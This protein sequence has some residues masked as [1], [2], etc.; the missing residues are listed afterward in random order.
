MDTNLVS[1][2]SMSASDAAVIGG[3]AGSIITSLL[4]FAFVMFI[5]QV[6][7]GWKIFAKAGEPGWKALIPIYNTYIFYKIVGMKNYF[8]GV[9]GLA[10]LA[11]IVAGATGFDS[12]N[13]Q[14]NSMSGANLVGAITYIVTGVISCV[15][16]IIYCV[17]TS[18]AFG[19]GVGF[20]LGLIFLNP[21]FLLILGFGSSKYDKKLVASWT[22]K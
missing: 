5:L 4:I 3:V 12:N 22:K 13:L 9:L 15:I 11:G 2:N 7:A 20:T 10:V 21:L 16:E 8:W 1:T 19:H 14:N 18:N 17:R 6:I